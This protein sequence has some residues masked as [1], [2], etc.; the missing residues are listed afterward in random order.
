MVRPQGSEATDPDAA[1]AELYNETVRKVFEH[2][3][4]DWKLIE[5]RLVA[6]VSDGAGTMGAYVDRLNVVREGA[7]REL[8][9][10]VKDAAHCLMQAISTAKGSVRFWY[11]ALDDVVAFLACFYRTSSKRMRGSLR[12]GGKFFFSRRTGVRRV[13]AMFHELDI[14]LENLPVIL[15]HLAEYIE[16]EVDSGQRDKAEGLLEALLHPLF[17]LTATFFLRCFCCGLCHEQKN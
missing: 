9:A 6:A 1:N 8:I 12:K 17:K 15:L 14:V 5:E 7:R 4:I 11:D 2:L 16:I 13:E 10:W 3:E